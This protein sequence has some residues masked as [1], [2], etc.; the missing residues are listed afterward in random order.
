MGKSGIMNTVVKKRTTGYHG[1]ENR[2][3]SHNSD[4]DDVKGFDCDCK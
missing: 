3:N 1:E 2:G 4:E